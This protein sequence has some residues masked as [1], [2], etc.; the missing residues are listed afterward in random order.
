MESPPSGIALACMRRA[1]LLLRGIAQ[2]KP[3]V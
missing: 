2:I 1:R 3:V